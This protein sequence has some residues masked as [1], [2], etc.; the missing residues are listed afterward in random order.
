MS[1]IWKES[2]PKVVLVLSYSLATTVY[3]PLLSS[4]LV[5]APQSLSA[6]QLFHLMYLSFGKS[7]KERV[8]EVEAEM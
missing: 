3:L 6:Q 4:Q 7:P 2:G 8:E 5:T 1:Q